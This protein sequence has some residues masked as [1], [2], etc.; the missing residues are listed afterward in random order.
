R[1]A[2]P[3]C[4]RAGSPAR[5][6]GA[7]V[8]A[9]VVRVP[10]QQV[11]RTPHSRART[12]VR[13]LACTR[14]PTERH[15]MSPLKH[16]NHLAARMGR[17]SASHWKI[18]V[19]GWLALVALLFVAGTKIG[20]NTISTQDQNVGQAHRAD[21][22]LKHSGFGQTD[23]QTEIVLVQSAKLTPGDPAFKAAVNDVART[24]APFKAIKNLRTP[25]QGGHADQISKDRHSVL[26]LWEMKGNEDAAKKKIDAITTATDK[27]AT[28]HPSFYIGEA[29]SISSGKALDALFSK[30]LSNAG[31]RSVPLTLIILLLVF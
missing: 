29:G 12:P 15:R 4:R 1:K 19:F 17:W 28:R 24:V 20:M 23:P 3:P 21:N 13:R 14:T 27:V 6:R 10:A 2:A 31:T 25:Y 16:S 30:Q 8:P 11:S 18:A 26:V 22:I 5:A 7:R 9:P